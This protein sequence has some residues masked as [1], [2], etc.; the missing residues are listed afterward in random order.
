M[1]FLII[2]NVIFQ[3]FPHPRLTVGSTGKKDIK[4]FLLGGVKFASIVY[5]TIFGL[6]CL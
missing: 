4:S 3:D 1:S 2:I 6:S 5:F